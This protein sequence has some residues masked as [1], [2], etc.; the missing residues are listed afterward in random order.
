MVKFKLKEVKSRIFLMEFTDQYNMCMTFL[1]YQ[2]FYESPCSKFR[3]KQFTLV[4]FMEW[5]AKQHKGVFTYPLDWG[6]FNIPSS[7]IDKILYSDN[8][9]AL[10]DPNKYDAIMQK[11]YSKC[12]EKVQRKYNTDKFYIIG[13][14]KG[15]SGI[16]N[17]EISHGFFY[18]IPEYKK[19]MTAL[20]KALKPSFRKSL[21]STLKKLGY[22]HQVYIDECQA[23][24]ST[25]LTTQFKVKLKGEDKPF[26][27][28]FNKY[29]K[30]IK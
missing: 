29:N 4:D 15:Q 8:C 27:E 20:V 5:Y 22:T 16:L 12:L 10:K 25:G 13:A 30:L 6:G 11:V 19:E 26:I 21:Y 1:R 23:Y 2:E 9:S 3:N 7:V 17:H 18:T 28:L 24:M 14:K